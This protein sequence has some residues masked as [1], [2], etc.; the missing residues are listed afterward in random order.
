MKQ[1][2]NNKRISQRNYYEHIIMNNESLKRITEY[3]LN[4]PE[5]WSE[6]NKYEK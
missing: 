1:V 2:K 6:I 5:K 3:I 4:N